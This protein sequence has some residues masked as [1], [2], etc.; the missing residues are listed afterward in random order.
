M[1]SHPSRA[2]PYRD[3]APEDLVKEAVDRS[4]IGV[5]FT[6]NEPMVWAE[7]IL[8]VAQVA[9]RSGLFVALNTNGYVLARAADDLLRNVD[10][11]K[12]DI[13]GYSEEVYAGTCGGSLAPVLE[14][15][16]QVKRSGK[17]LELSYLMIPG[18]TDGLDMLGRFGAWVMEILG[19]DVPLHLY[20]FQP[21]ARMSDL[22]PEPIPRMLEARDLM[23]GQGV[24]YVY[25]GG[26]TEGRF[27][28]TLCPNCSTPVITRNMEE[29]EP[30]FVMGE[31]VSRFC[32]S[33]SKIE[34]A[35]K[36]TSCPRCGENIAVSYWPH[37]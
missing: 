24:R 18:I 31:R 16:A 34:N 4:A 29:S 23:M 11:V 10:V 27:R 19:P 15:C 13:K 32:P 17:H 7:Y 8:D 30:G 35:L 9:H 20:R 5:A 37:H 14:L 2:V 25:L 3:V 12:V 21:S 36:G 1:L 28:N 26:E 22:G 33:F 6:F